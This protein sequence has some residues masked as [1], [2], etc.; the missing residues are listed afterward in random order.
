M[1]WLKYKIFSHVNYTSNWFP[2]STF[3]VNC[4]GFNSVSENIVALDQMP[5]LG[6]AGKRLRTCCVLHKASAT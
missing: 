1:F 6:S 5:L 4:S 3:F 2:V